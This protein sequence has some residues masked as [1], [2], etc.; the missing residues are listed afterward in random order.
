[1][2]KL[3]NEHNTK[4]KLN[5]EN[6][7]M[8]SNHSKNSIFSNISDF[9]KSHSKILL[10]D[11]NN[12]DNNTDQN[13]NKERKIDKLEEFSDFTKN[14]TRDFRN[15]KKQ[16]S[17]IFPLRTLGTKMYKLDN[18]SK[19]KTIEKNIQKKILGIS[20]KIE[21]ESSLIKEKTI[22]QLIKKKIMNQSD[23]EN[24][25]FISKS[26][27]MLKN[28]KIK[29]FSTKI[30][31]MNY[32][33]IEA[34]PKDENKIKDFSCILFSKHKKRKIKKEKF[35]TL[36]KKKALYDSFDSEEEEELD[37]F[38]I[39]PNNKLI[40]LLDSLVI[41]STL[42][43]MVYTPYYLSI[44]KC[45]CSK[46]K[47]NLY[48]IYIFIDILYIFDLL[49][50]FFRAYLDF[51]FKLITN[52]SHI[53]RH[54]L[55]SQFI[56]DLIQAIPFLSFM[57]YY[58][59]RANGFYNCTKVNMDSFHFLLL[60][61]C[62][63]KQLKIFK[64]LNIKKNAVYYK[65]KICISKYDFAEKI[66]DFF[67]YLIVCVFAIYFFISVH[68]FIGKHSYPNWI[69]RAK[70]QDKELFSLYLI[71]FYYLITTM[72]TVGY[73][74]IVSSSF[75]EII[76]Q[77]ILLS[78]GIIIYSFI[79]SS[80]GNYVKNENHASMKF[81]K[82]EAILEGI[83]ISYPNMPFKLYN[84][85]FHHLSARKIS[86]LHCDYNIL[87]NSLPYSLKSQVLLAMHQQTI[88]NFKI[89]RGYKNTDF[90]LRILKNFIPLF[91]KKN[92]L[93]IH[94]GELIENIIFVK[95]GRLSLEA[96]I[97]IKEPCKSIIQYLNKNFIDIDENVVIVSNYETSLNA[98]E[99]TVKNYKNNFNK[100][101]T[102]LDSVI[103]YKS[104]TNLDSSINE[105]NLGKEIGKWDLGGDIFKESNYQFIHII[106]ISKNESYGTVYMFLSKPSPLSLRVKSKNA[107]LLLLR[108]NEVKDITKRYPNIWT[109]FF[110]N[111]YKNMLSIKS[112]TIHKIKHY[113]KNLGKEIFNKQIFKKIK[114]EIK[115]KIKSKK[116]NNVGTII[117]IK[118]CS[119]IKDNIEN[120]QTNVSKTNKLFLSVRSNSRRSSVKSA[121]YKNSKYISFENEEN[122]SPK[123]SFKSQNN[124][125]KMSYRKSFIPKR[126]INIIGE[127]REVKKRFETICG[128]PTLKNLS[129]FKKFSSVH[130][131]SKLENTN[132]SKR[133]ILN[134]IK[135]RNIQDLRIEYLKKLK[136]KII[137]LKKSKK[138]YKNLCKSYAH[139]LN[140]NPI[141]ELNKENKSNANSNYY[142]LFDTKRKRNNYF[143]IK[144]NEKRKVIQDVRISETS[145]EKSCASINRAFNLE[146]MRISS[147][148]QLNFNSK[149]KNLDEYSLGE[150][151]KNNYLRHKILKFIRI[152]LANL[153]KKKKDKEI[154]VSSV[155][156]FNTGKWGKDLSPLNSNQK[157]PKFNFYQ[158]KSTFSFIKNS[159][160][161]IANN[162]SKKQY[163]MIYDAIKN[164]FNLIKK[165]SH[166]N[167]PNTKMKKLGKQISVSND[168]SKKKNNENNASKRVVRSLFSINK[169]SKI[170]VLKNDDTI[171]ECENESNFGKKY[172]K[173]L[174]LFS[175]V[176][177]NKEI[178]GSDKDKKCNK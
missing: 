100:A 58:C 156:S 44:V 35:R 46:T 84:K 152:Y 92:V 43:N 115:N 3:K 120:M 26:N 133:K 102:V 7:E 34:S 108:K 37:K 130:Y 98:S 155:K 125:D 73:G 103:N 68:I 171:V 94:N 78:V 131:P 76:F 19:M 172:Q 56:F 69:I 63:L 137:A 117:N 1:M 157:E 71:S 121:S 75:N 8:N 40:Q 24:S 57:I 149:Y 25:S 178:E 116:I 123:K 61:C 20:M 17:S 159:P 18:L 2:I 67:I 95:E 122:L 140:S 41:I 16:K 55:I 127:Q 21:K 141:N 54:Y 48:N 96:S 104:K 170:D 32:I 89:F 173:D 111:S 80:I 53:I 163:V 87:I 147:P 112:I 166:Y 79:V 88:K 49:F 11:K 64:I 36:F 129:S 150:Y 132:F 154:F 74:D 148:I 85:I 83:R 23:N 59:K 144:E 143:N 135:K 91:S 167:R 15:F 99:F 5:Q 28:D 90:I 153:S 51:Q 105:S 14:K 118:E 176:F 33:N 31:N 114:K 107:E 162:I 13:E 62:T 86:Q 77:L 106:N 65:L 142:E 82:D 151:S 169:L 128:G 97:S 174:E 124:N 29:S 136:R 27:V 177:R 22:S 126:N 161:N 9:H 12:S 119:V 10:K 70:F 134:K 145:N 38:F 60:L 110:K 164:T 138:Y 30:I 72:T 93:L 4:K 47:S 66:L 45:F 52:H 50:G 113:W 146:D 158:K 109:K 42:F 165:K 39:S 160:K 81:D 101:K 139:N 168:N 6:F 175:N